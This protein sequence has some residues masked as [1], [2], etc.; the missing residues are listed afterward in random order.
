MVKGLKGPIKHGERGKG[1]NREVET[2]NEHSKKPQDRPANMHIARHSFCIKKSK[3]KRNKR[4]KR[5]TRNTDKPH[6]SKRQKKDKGER[7]KNAQKRQCN[8]AKNKARKKATKTVA[9]FVL[10]KTLQAGKKRKE[11]SERQGK[12]IYNDK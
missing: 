1:G 10:A 2:Q 5:K 7:A 11:N 3:K 9:L 12:F 6:D 4:T 8:T